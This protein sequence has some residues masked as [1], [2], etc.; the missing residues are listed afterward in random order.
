MTRESPRS[1]HTPEGQG[2]V[3]RPKPGGAAATVRH[4]PQSPG[5][6][7]NREYEVMSC[8]RSTDR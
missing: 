1:G 4:R 6:P 7:R 8:G 3:P 5:S 2:A